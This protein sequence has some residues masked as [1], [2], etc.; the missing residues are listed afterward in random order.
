MDTS[1]NIPVPRMFHPHPNLADEVNDA[2]VRSEIEGGVFLDH[3]PEDAT[4]EV[5]TENRNYRIVNKGRGRALISGHPQFCPQPVMVGIH[6]STWGGSML[7]VGYIGRGM[8]ME[9]GYPPFGVIVTSRI[10][11]I[12]QLQ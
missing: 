9:F 3:L 8:R 7:K 4:L 5:E 11:E 10:R 12:R 6:G 1:T 2:I